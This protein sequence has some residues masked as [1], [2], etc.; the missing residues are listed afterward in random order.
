M[1]TVGLENERYFVT[2]VDVKTKSGADILIISRSE[3]P[4]ISKATF[5]NFIR[6]YGRVPLV[7]VSNNARKYISVAVI[8]TI[9]VKGRASVSTT[10]YTPRENGT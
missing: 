2:M 10:L 1:T 4:H 9:Q 6:E 5:Y 3:V 8:K 7:F